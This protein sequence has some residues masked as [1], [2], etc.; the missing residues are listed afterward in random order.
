MIS[1]YNYVSPRFLLYIERYK[2]KISSHSVIYLKMI[3]DYK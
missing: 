1:N 2:Y 3:T